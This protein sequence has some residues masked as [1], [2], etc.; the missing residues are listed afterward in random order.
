MRIEDGFIVDV[1]K[2]CDRWCGRCVLADRCRLN[3]E[4]PGPDNGQ[5][6]F[7]GFNADCLPADMEVSQFGPDPE[8]V[9]KS[10]SLRRKT[11]RARLSASASVRLACETVEYLTMFVTVTTFR[12]IA[13][14]SRGETAG[15]QSSANGYGKA[16][17]LALE[18]MRH[19]WRILVDTRH[20]SESDV[21]PFLREIERMERNVIRIAPGA[22]RFVRPGF[23]E[24][25]EVAMLQ[26]KTK[27]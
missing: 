11:N 27:H 16:A 22:G 6:T 20:F 3:V 23:D 21:A 13:A 9:A 18:R 10:A 15:D 7:D 24:P 26:A 8:V 12:A 2:F 5:T 25:A 1:F 4:G 14:R 19:A 17:L